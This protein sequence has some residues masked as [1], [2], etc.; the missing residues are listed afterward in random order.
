MSTIDVTQWA[1]L[2]GCPFCGSAPC[3]TVLP[4]SKTCYFI[5][6]TVACY[7]CP[8]RPQYSQHYPIGKTQNVYDANGKYTGITIERHRTDQEAFKAMITYLSEIWNK[9][10]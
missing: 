4:S 8:I 1:K 9:R 7:N 6:G 2:K 3:M 10:S 5:M